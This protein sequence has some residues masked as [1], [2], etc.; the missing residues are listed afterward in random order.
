MNGINSIIDA[1]TYNGYYN[2][3]TSGYESKYKYINSIAIGGMT[4][5]D[6]QSAVIEN[7]ASSANLDDVASLIKFLNA[8]LLVALADMFPSAAYSLMK[9]N[10][11]MDRKFDGRSGIRYNSIS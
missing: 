10:L 7:N 5:L 1:D 2:R 3:W 6:Y 8:D 4:T 9:E 11:P